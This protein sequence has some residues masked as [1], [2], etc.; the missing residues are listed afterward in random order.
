VSNQIRA[1]YFRSK[2]IDKDTAGNLTNLYSDRLFN[3]GTRTSALLHGKYNEAVPL[4]LFVVGYRGKESHMKFLNFT[5]NVG[6]S[7]GDELQYLFNMGRFEEI[8]KSEKD[9][10]FSNKFIKLWL[11]F[12]REGVPSATWS[13]A[14]KWVPVTPEQ[15]K[16][17][18]ALRFY[19][20]DQNCSFVDEP[21]T[22]R[23]SFWD[24]LPLNELNHEISPYRSDDIMG[25]MS[26]SDMI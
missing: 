19:R 22:E 14:R 9:A 12:A 6:V 23:M 3:H 26:M 7:E 4:Y 2:P 10:D 16:G 1:F 25:G 15:V 21:F 20:L 18:E 11:S 13:G 24:N 8:G 5:E 17:D